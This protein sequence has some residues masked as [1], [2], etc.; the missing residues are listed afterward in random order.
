MVTYSAYVAAGDHT[1][2]NTDNS[3]ND[4]TNKHNHANY[5]SDNYNFAK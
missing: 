4:A 5:I 3:D 2:N 1:V